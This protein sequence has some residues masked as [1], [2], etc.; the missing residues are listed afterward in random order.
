MIHTERMDE[1]LAELAAASG[2]DPGAAL[3][4][5]LDH[6]DVPLG[7]VGTPDEVAAAIVFL[8]SAAGGYVTGAQLV[9]DGGLIPTT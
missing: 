6:Y 8:V 5:M 7:R 2:Q 9:V 3:R 1:R 4:T